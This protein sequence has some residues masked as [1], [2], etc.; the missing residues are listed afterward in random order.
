MNETIFSTEHNVLEAYNVPSCADF[1]QSWSHSEF[2]FLLD[3][4]CWS[5]EQMSKFK[6]RPSYEMERKCIF[7]L[8]WSNQKVPNSDP[9]NCGTYQT[10]NYTCTGWTSAKLLQWE[11]RLFSGHDPYLIWGS[12]IESSVFQDMTGGPLSVQEVLFKGGGPANM[13]ILVY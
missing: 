5:G 6:T 10:K 7:C 1:C 12:E 8:F 11:S 3:D 2:F 4:T 9:Q 13:R